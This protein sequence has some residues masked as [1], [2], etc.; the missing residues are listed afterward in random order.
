M[1]GLTYDMSDPTERQ[2]SA[3]ANFVEYA[4]RMAAAV[5]SVDP[6]G[7]VTIGM[8][9]FGAVRRPGPQGM[10]AYCLDCDGEYRYPA[11]PR[12]LAYWSDLDFLDIHIYPAH[13]PGIND[14]YTLDRNLQTIEWDHVEGMPV[15][16]DEFG[17][18]KQFYSQDITAA[19]YG[20]RYMQ[21]ATCQRGMSGWL[22]W[23][24]NPGDMPSLQRFYTLTDQGGAI[25]GQ[26]API[27]RPN[28]CSR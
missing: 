22:F 25:N 6:E 10:P 5:K 23:T 12:S 7:L 3:D 9:T 21:V 16:V 2:Q 8:F 20:M 1:N 15:I 26:L 11:R 14:P 28:P 13:K 19:A 17:A 18:D 27:V 24:S 4:N